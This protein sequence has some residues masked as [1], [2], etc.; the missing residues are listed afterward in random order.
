MNNQIIQ[1][2]GQILVF[3]ALAIGGWQLMFSAPISPVATPK[4]VSESLSGAQTDPIKS[5]QSIKPAQQ[6]EAATALS[7]A[8]T[9]T[10]VD[11]GI[12]GIFF[13]ELRLVMCPIVSAIPVIKDIVGE[14]SMQ[15]G[16]SCPTGRMP[17]NHNR[18]VSAWGTQK[19]A[20]GAKRTVSKL[21]V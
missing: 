4:L 20:T 5:A 17:S 16:F 13:D 11:F 18:A 14:L 19:P 9:K 12:P 1:G 6:L 7:A 15:F 3:G 8:A 10:E 2:A 21:T